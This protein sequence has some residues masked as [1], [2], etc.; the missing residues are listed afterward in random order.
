VPV[1]VSIS[2]PNGVI[3]P[4]ET[5]I[6][7]PLGSQLKAAAA[8]SVLNDSGAATAG[9]LEARVR[10]CHA[11]NDYYQVGMYD[12]EG[13]AHDSFSECEMKHEHIFGCQLHHRWQSMPVVWLIP[14]G[15]LCICILMARN[16]KTQKGSKK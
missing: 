4:D 14:Y 3:R 9:V 10:L 7:L 15:W 1:V 2:S 8:A 16:Q 12:A 13:I 6:V 5:G 11:V